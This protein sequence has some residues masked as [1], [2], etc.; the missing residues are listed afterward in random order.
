MRTRRILLLPLLAAMFALASCAGPAKLAQ[1][2][3]EALAKGDLHKAYDRALRAVEKDPQNAA[4]R[5]AYDEASRRVSG[6]YRARVRAR[7]AT[8]SLSAADLAIEYRDFRAVVARN[9]SSLPADEAY[10]SEEDRIVTA[11]AREFYHRGRV[12]MTAR[13][14][15]EAWRNYGTSQHY[16]EN[17]ADV[18]RRQQDAWNAARTR[19]A[20]FPFEDGIG[21][22]GLSQEIAAQ[23]GQQVPGHAAGALSFTEFVDGSAI[24]GVMTVAQASH[25]SRDEAL[26]LGRKVGADRVV[27]GRFAG[28]RANNDLKDLTLPIY[29]KVD[30][31]DDK[32]GTITDWVESSLQVVTRERQVTVNW[33]FD[34]LDARSGVVLA[35]RTVP[36]ATAARVVWSDFKPEGDCDRYTLLPPDVRRNDTTRA[37]RVDS[38]WEERVGSWTLPSLLTKARDGRN[39]AHW[40]REYRGEFRG[41]DTRRRPV[42]LGELPGEDD[43]AFVALDSAW[44][45]VYTALQELDAK[46]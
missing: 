39:R 5:Q 19:V 34:V 36:A 13:R 40:S 4:A 16:V 32:G 15:K 12:A 26:A 45:D 24:A 9:G 21:V 8:D 1:Q 14:P 22:P 20:L 44:R 31:K 25:M 6:D 18:L 41:T 30:R 27:V 11:A 10:E 42:W 23:V 2:S 35:H 43:M 33:E 46:D 37:K 28:M 38:Q 3:Q 17:Y 7:A 29:R